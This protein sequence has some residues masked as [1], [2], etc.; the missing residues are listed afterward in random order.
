LFIEDFA[1]AFGL[2][3]TSSITFLPSGGGTV[4]FTPNLTI[5]LRNAPAGAALNV[6][7]DE[8]ET[9]SADH[10]TLLFT[11]TPDGTDKTWNSG[12]TAGNRVIMQWVPASPYAF[13]EINFPYVVP[14]D[15]AVFDFAPLLET[16]DGI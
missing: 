6:W 14:S 1:G 13:K 15:S 8:D 5:I 2:D 12:V 4:T 3:S 10:G 9:T 11:A 7:D 16:E